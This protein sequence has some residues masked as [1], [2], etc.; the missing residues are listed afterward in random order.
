MQLI[1]NTFVIALLSFLLQLILPWWIICMVGFVVSYFGADK[2]WQAFVAGFCA[3]FLLWFGYA[4]FID[5]GN[6]HLLSSKMVELFHLPNSLSLVI[7][8]A[9]VGGLACGLASLTG[10]L[11]R[12]IA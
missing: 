4:F 2:P 5:L 8:T 7:V 1:R 3:T 10:R 9:L 6:N 12:N 11:L